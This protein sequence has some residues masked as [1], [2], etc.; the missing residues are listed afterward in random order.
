MDGPC[1]LKMEKAVDKLVTLNIG[2]VVLRMNSE[3]MDTFFNWNVFYHLSPTIYN[4][5]N[6]ATKSQSVH[7]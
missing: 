6:I 2:D 1:F 5:N 4:R 7:A 3:G